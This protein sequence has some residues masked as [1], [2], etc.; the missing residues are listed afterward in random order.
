MVSF[1]PVTKNENQLNILD[2]L[3][4]YEYAQ[5]KIKT[6]DSDNLNRKIS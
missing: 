3:A 5:N 1:K 4:K 6:V 2:L